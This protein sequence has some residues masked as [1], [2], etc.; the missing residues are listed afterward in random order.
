[1]YIYIYICIYAPRFMP[2]RPFPSKGRVPGLPPPFPKG[3]VP[4]SS[5]RSPQLFL[6]C[7]SGNP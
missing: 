6:K 3:R 1:M 5:T 2:D 4:V 7:G